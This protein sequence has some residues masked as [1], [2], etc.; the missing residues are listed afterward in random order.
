MSSFIPLVS[1][2][3]SKRGNQKGQWNSLT[4]KWRLKRVSCWNRDRNDANLCPGYCINVSYV[5][6]R[7]INAN[8]NLKINYQRVLD[9]RKSLYNLK[10]MVWVN[11]KIWQP[12]S[13]FFWKN[14]IS[15]NHLPMKWIL[16]QFTNTLYCSLNSTHYHNKNI[17]WTNWKFNFL[18]IP[19][20]CWKSKQII[21]RLTN[22]R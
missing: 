2:G 1:F 13:H 20:P 7:K 5:F 4:W 22:S 12:K 17:T 18:L 9:Y 11:L 14:W 8:F 21:H 19:L 10:S 16:T 3:V 15:Q 6:I